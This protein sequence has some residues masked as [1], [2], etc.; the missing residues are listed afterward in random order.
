MF[1]EF[2]RHFS[3]LFAQKRKVPGKGFGKKEWSL[4]RWKGAAP[5]KGFSTFSSTAL[6]REQCIAFMGIM[7]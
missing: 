1:S 6:Y 2:E 5:A 3:F 4:M 7:V